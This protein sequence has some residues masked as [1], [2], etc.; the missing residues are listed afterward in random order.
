MTVVSLIVVVFLIIISNYFFKKNNK[1]KVYKMLEDWN[2]WLVVSNSEYKPFLSGKVIRKTDDYQFSLVGCLERDSLDAGLL[3]DLEV[4][5]GTLPNLI[6]C[7]CIVINS[8][9]LAFSGVENDEQIKHIYH[10][11]PNDHSS[12]VNLIIQDST[13]IIPENSEDLEQF[14]QLWGCTDMQQ[15]KINDY[16][17]K[18]DS[19]FS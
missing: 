8:S 10:H 19:Y 6:P 7:K 17:N 14:E 16:E 1:K 9:G 12:C 3:N 18:L 15:V 2:W 13:I 4:K 5:I 11:I